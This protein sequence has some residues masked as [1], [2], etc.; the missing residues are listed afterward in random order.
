[1]RRECR[2]ERVGWVGRLFFDCLVAAWG[3]GVSTNEEEKKTE[4]QEPEK[5]QELYLETGLGRRGR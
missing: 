3:A 4:Q 5:D 2:A 1:M